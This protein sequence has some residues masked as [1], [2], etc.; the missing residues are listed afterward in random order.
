MLLMAAQT[1]HTIS[2]PLISHTMMR[3]NRSASSPRAHRS[4]SSKTIPLL[5][6]NIIHAI[7]YAWD[8]R[9]TGHNRLRAAIG[10]IVEH[11]AIPR[12]GLGYYTGCCIAGDF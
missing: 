5:E 4:G 2:L 11:R 8:I 1:S 7:A 10:F 9:R 12:L 6:P 3:S